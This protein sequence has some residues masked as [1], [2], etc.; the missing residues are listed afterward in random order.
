MK[1]DLNRVKEKIRALKALAADSG[2]TEGEVTAALNLAQKLCHEY[3]LNLADIEDDRE[4]QVELQVDK[5]VRD[6][7]DFKI[8]Q[9]L[10]MDGAIIRLF[11][12]EYIYNDCRMTETIMGTETDRTTADYCIDF[13]HNTMHSAWEKYKRS[14]E[15]SLMR[16][17]F[18]AKQLK[19]DFMIGFIHGVADKCREM[20]Q[21]QEDVKLK[22]TGTSLIIVKSAAVEEF[23]KKT[24]PYLKTVKTRAVTIH[25]ERTVEAGR[26]QGRSIEFT[27]PITGAKT[28]CHPSLSYR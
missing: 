21:N 13:A 3:M 4:I 5:L 7:R 12:C 20:K 25:A 22:T 17:R 18:R 16:E 26:E 24:F 9:V 11:D 27:K 19:R 23:K 1:E 15:Y 2:A 8:R 6:L 14:Y 10:H 28:E